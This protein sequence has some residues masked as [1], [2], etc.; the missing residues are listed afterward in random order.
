MKRKKI[1][2]PVAAVLCAAIAA[3]VALLMFAPPEVREWSMAAL[4]PVLVA[5][6][7]YLRSPRDTARGGE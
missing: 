1:T 2:G 7:A 4:M 5:V 3:P 6:A